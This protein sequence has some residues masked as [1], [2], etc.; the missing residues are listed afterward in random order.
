MPL[1]NPRRPTHHA[2]GRRDLI[3]LTTITSLAGVLRFWNLSD[4]ARLIF[5]EV[6]YAKRAC[7]VVFA[8]P[9]TC[10]LLGRPV[11]VHPPLGKLLI[12]IG[13]EVLGFSPLGW[14]IVPALAGTLTVALTF[15]LARVL[16][17]STVAAS[18]SAALVAICFL[19][20]VQSRVAMLDVFVGLF[21]LAAFLFAAYDRA[22]LVRRTSLPAHEH[23][24]RLWQPVRLGAGIAI[25]AAAASK[26]SGFLTW[27][28]VVVLLFAWITWTRR[29][30]GRRS[31]FRRLASELPSIVLY[32]G[33]VPILVYAAVYATQIDGDVLRPFAADGWATTF[34]QEQVRLFNYHAYFPPS[35]PHESPPWAW[36]LLKRPVVY[37]FCSGVTCD[38]DISKTQVRE[39]MA[40]GN[41]LTWWVSLLAIAIIALRWIRRRDPARPDGLILMGFAAT[42][43]P[44]FLLTLD[45]SQVFLFYLLPTLPFMY[46]ALASVARE[47]VPAWE[48]KLSVLVFSVASAGLFVYYLPVLSAQSVSAEAWRDRLWIFDQCGQHA[49]D[50]PQTFM[51]ARPAQPVARSTTRLNGESDHEET[52]GASGWCW[53]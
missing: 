52:L 26:W 2:W 36:P 18:I 46:L 25:G 37:F 16:L 13:I 23:H 40:T 8:S 6:Y 24:V 33:A 41:P 4:P 48:G 38:P 47:I 45:R 27:V 14:R 15:W 17:R 39:V 42:Y 30:D 20:F 29:S 32:F 12:A 1:R 50:E 51:P 35:H 49:T 3:A 34:W 5:D 10:E 19:H 21:S 53:A 22:A 28:G 7:W 31:A 44:W 11:D 9:E 43:L